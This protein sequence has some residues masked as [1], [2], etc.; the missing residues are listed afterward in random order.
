M[1]LR[2]AV[3]SCVLLT[4]LP[5]VAEEEAKPAEV[6]QEIQISPVRLNISTRWNM[7]TKIESAEELKTY[8]G[9]KEPAG[10]LADVDFD[11]SIILVFTWAGSGQDKMSYEVDDNGDKPTINFSMMRGRTRD[12]RPHRHAYL[13]AKGVQYTLGGK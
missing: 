13:I 1:L 9:D 6:I 8:L 11:K 5:A 2:I 3:V 7:P 10:A 12:L 4:A